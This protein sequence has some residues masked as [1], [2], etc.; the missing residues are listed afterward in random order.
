MILSIGC[1]PTNPE[2]LSWGGAKVL[3]AN[4]VGEMFGFSLVAIAENSASRELWPYCVKSRLNYLLSWC[5]PQPTLSSQGASIVWVASSSWPGQYA[6]RVFDFLGTDQDS[7]LPGGPVLHGNFRTLSW[8]INPESDSSTP[9]NNF[10]GQLIPWNKYL[11]LHLTR[12]NS[13]FCNWTLSPALQLSF[14]CTSD[15]HIF[16]LAE[17]TWK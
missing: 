14:L 10:V 1:S 9:H 11:L 17:L 2:S 5:E 13:I 4:S 15:P 12:M 8:T 6:S 3:P 7:N 16:L